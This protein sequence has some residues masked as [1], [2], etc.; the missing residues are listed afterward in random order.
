MK[1]FKK[2]LKKKKKIRKL[3]IK[4]KS[5]FS[6]FQWNPILCLQ[7]MHD[8]V[9]FHCSIY[10]CRWELLWKLLYRCKKFQVW[11]IL[12]RPLYEMTEYA[13]TLL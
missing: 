11:K 10:Y 1:W 2:Y 3:K 5:L 8:C 4:K 6:K 13:F 9:I 7:I 12:L